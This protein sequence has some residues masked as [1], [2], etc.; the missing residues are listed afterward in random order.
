M[1]VNLALTTT[2][3]QGRRSDH[4]LDVPDAATVA[5]LGSV[6]GAADLFL[7]DRRLNPDARVGASGIR[8]GAVIGLGAPAPTA[9]ATRAWRPPGSDPVLVTVRHVSGP[10]AG[11]VWRLG[12]GRHEV[13]T[14]RA[15]ALR[16]DGGG[17]PAQGTW[18]TVGTDG[19]LTVALP[20]DAD[21]GD[22]GL[23]SLTPPPPV[24]PITGTPLS[25]EEPAGT[26]EGGPGG[27]STE[28]P[29]TGPD[30]QPVQPP[31]PPVGRL[32][33]L[34]D[35]SLPWPTYA[36]LS[37]GEHLLRPGPPEE[38]EAAVRP[39]PDGLG[40]EYNRPPR[41]APHLDAESI[42]M[43]G[44]PTDNSKRPFPF[45]MMIAP[46]LMGLAMMFL[47]RSLFFV[48]FVFFTPLMAV[49]N[50]I[51]GKRTGRRDYQEA[52]RVYRIRRSALEAEM[53]RATVEER[54]LRNS[55]FPDPAALLLTATGPGLALW[56][57]RRRD[58]DH[59]TIR[60]GTLT[61]ASL[62]SIDDQAR[63][64][65]YRNVNWRIADVP[66][67]VEMTA[68][69]VVGIG[70]SG[71]L[72]RRIASWAVIQTAVLHSPR[73]VRVVVLT[74]DE[75]ADA[76]QWVRWL[77]HLRPGRPGAA[78]VALGTDPESTA[79]RVNELIADV[80][81]RMDSSQSALGPTLQREPDVL[82]ILDGARRL[83]DVP[84]MIDVLTNGPAVRVFSL[85]LEEREH[86]LPEECTAVVTANGGRLDLKASHVPEVKGIR[87]DL[88]DPAWCEEVA[89]ALAPVLDVTVES[90]SGLPAQVALLPLIGQEPPDAEVLLRAWARRPASTTFVLGSGYE[91]VLR[92]DL[93]RDGPHGLIGGTT[94]SGKSEL[95]QTMIASL[96]AV[97]RPDELT[98]VLVD[99]KGGSAFRECAELP[100]TLGMITDLDGHL[101]K[102]ALAS[103]DAELRRRET[104]LNEVE[105]KDHTEY[106]IKRARDP[107][108]APL[109][110]LLLVI[111]EFATLVRELPDFVPGLI[112]LAQRGRSLGLHLLL[113]TQRPGGSVSNEI[114][115]NTNLRMA[116]RVTD[117]SESQDIIDGIEA[118]GISP[119]NPGRALV[120]RGEGPPTPFQ[121]AFVGAERPGAVPTSVTKAAASRPVR[122]IRLGWQRL[123]R[124]LD[125][126][127]AEA[128]VENDMD[129]GPE[130]HFGP[131]DDPTTGQSEELPTDL[132]ALVDAL[133]EAADR[134]PDFRPQPS[135]WLP[136]MDDR[137]RL[138]ELPA[139]PEPAPGALPMVPYALLDIPQLQARRLAAIDFASFGHLYVIGAPRSG[140]TQVLRT[141][142]GAA[143][144]TIPCSDLHIYAIDAA[145]GG[146]SVLEALPHCGAVVSRHDAE[147]MER[148]INRLTAELTLRQRLIA[149]HDCADVTE[150]R[151]RVGKDQRPAHLVL[152]V[153][154]W[155]A[156]STMLDDYDGGRLYADVVR[157]LREG[158]GAGIHVIAT[159]ERLLLGG[160]L[161]AHNDHRLLLRQTDPGDYTLIGM[162]RN[163]IPA[164]VAPGRGWLAPGAIEAQIALLPS[165][166]EAPV[167]A[168]VDGEDPSAND[169]SDQAEAMRELGRRATVRDSTVP[170]VRRPFRVNEMPTLI[171]FQ[172]AHDRMPRSLRKPFHA[173]LGVGGDAVA[174]LTY[175]FADG[176]GSFMVAGPPRSGRTTALAAMCVSLL[177]G[178]TRLVVLTPRDSQLRKLSAHGLAQ[179]LA[180]PDPEPEAL[181][182]ALTSV[183]EHP[184]VVV[185]DDADLMLAC[186]ADSVLRRIATSGRDHGQGL[187]L[188]GLAESMSSLGWV[189]MARR[190]R[191]G[192][193]L[194]PKTLGEADLI[195]ARLSAEQVRTPLGPGRG[196]TAGDSGAAIAVQVPLTVLDG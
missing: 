191:R 29:P 23:R 167:A 170:D 114:K 99:Y 67:G 101:V 139:I 77:P 181:V 190:S 58:S 120:R 141:I 12:P 56:Q 122:G 118:A 98:F 173:L 65:H 196:W 168:A 130:A 1:P 15:C 115:A 30:G 74:E 178:G 78:V 28:P 97:N 148:L 44:P 68:F 162:P 155:D 195:G 123:G 93:V 47:F 163:S 193:L 16:L 24:D 175:D 88:V 39:A 27:H 50:W 11:R 192:L 71:E 169:Q 9:T 119:N 136:P 31:L 22:C 179:V 63:E 73:D 102:R 18:I 183:R 86:L 149:R 187:L 117:R 137:M 17:A 20:D 49:G 157:L 70:A 14:D 186:A 82:V 143:A 79:H 104:V 124:P 46:L 3:P 135:P 66:F 32:P 142:A 40:I 174:P 2:D 180:D 159:S 25:T 145:G 166:A 96:A 4:L 84:G 134:L 128:D 177:M 33:A 176:G 129:T 147:R 81:T 113:A 5:D 184:V 7:G 153:D 92:L 8:A 52:K 172:E 158:Q 131:H 126:S 160:R 146:L 150:L 161:A 133:C 72:P 106:R 38:P 41:I 36:D 42:R 138:D 127:E 111:D 144:L 109:P 43:M 194:G 53:R 110:R 51:S 91:G 10:G 80:Q 95:L 171:G 48:I 45:L 152:M 94:G 125:F 37:L 35:G 13:G 19:S 112:S 60:L 151:G 55:T 103:L 156:L 6:L 105:A 57:R 165:I 189:G 61:R 26:Q 21:E 89:R 100:H 121:T 76:W 85:C 87:A 83:R 90:D 154:G 69:G 62:K 107:R 54:G 140:R 164:A 108:L 188:A 132:R 59:L 64:N 116:L 185:V 182:E 75:H 34:D